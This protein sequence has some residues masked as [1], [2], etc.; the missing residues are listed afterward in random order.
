MDSVHTSHRIAVPVHKSLRIGTLN[1]IL[2]AVAKHKNVELV[3][4]LK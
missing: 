3:E 2:R 1:A 4:I